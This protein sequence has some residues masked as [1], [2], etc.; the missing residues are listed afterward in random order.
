MAIDAAKYFN[1][2]II[3]ADSRQCYK[4]LSIGVAR[5]SIQELNEVPHHFIASHSIH[6]NITAAFFEQY[7]LTKCIE[8]FSRH[9]IIIMAG[10]TGLYLKAFCEGLDKIP[11]ID[12]MIRQR[13]I[14]NYEE[15]GIEW[16][17]S[18]LAAKDPVYTERGEMQN[19]Q[20]MMRALEVF[21][22]TGHSIFS[23]R[24]PG[25]KQ[26]DFNIIKYCLD[27]PKEQLL[28]QINKRVDQ[29][30]ANGLLDEAM[31]MIPFRNLNALQT[32]G[33][34]EA[35]DF[36]DGT[37]S[38]E[39]AVEQVKINTRQYAKRQLTWFRKDKEF[40]W[41]HPGDLLKNLAEMFPR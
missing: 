29:M 7:A 9:D 19:P 8:L 11:E 33:Y 16:L 14:V 35:F 12:Q 34:K 30:F 2:E 38:L 22:A 18:E 21:D 24:N 28:A 41:V 17:V 15:K 10:G 40:K 36:L 4:E 27:I 37:I 5:P 13:I 26:R 39:Q 6:E 31:K 20:R 25:K 3:S 1:T 32:V 23:F